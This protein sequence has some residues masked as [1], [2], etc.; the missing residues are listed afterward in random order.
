MA[1]SPVTSM[2]EQ[3]N[4]LTEVEQKVFLDLVDPQPE[5]EAPA[6]KTRKKRAS[7]SAK[8]QSLSSAI[9]KAPKVDT[10]APAI[11]FAQ[12]PGLDVLCGEP[13]DALIHDPKGGYSSYHPFAASA[14]VAAKRSSRKSSV[15]ASTANSETEKE[16]VLAVGASAGD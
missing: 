2:V 12:V 8:A 16:T 14:P 13:E 3:Y 11:C 9:A 1:R 15:A 4:A 5:P 6:V 10:N 7:K